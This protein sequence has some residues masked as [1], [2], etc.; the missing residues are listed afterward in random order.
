MREHAINTLIQ[1]LNDNQGNRLSS[2]LSIG[3][4]SLL[5]QEL[6]RYEAEHA[7]EPPVEIDDKMDE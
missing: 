7:P 5:N 2:A 4:A 3:V 1:L 6:Q